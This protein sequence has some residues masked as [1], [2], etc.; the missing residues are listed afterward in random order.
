M[1]RAVHTAHQVGRV[2]RHIQTN[3]YK[4]SELTKRLGE[5]A[6]VKILEGFSEEFLV[7]TIHVGSVAVH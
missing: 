6:E 5:M 7:G 4:G 2:A 3:A 1:L